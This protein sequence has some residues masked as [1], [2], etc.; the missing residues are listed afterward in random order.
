MAT[1]ATTPCETLDLLATT[2]SGQDRRHLGVVP[3]QCGRQV[4]QAQ[5]RQRLGH[6]GGHLSTSA[7]SLSHGALGL[8]RCVLFPCCSWPF[9]SAARPPPLACGPSQ[10]H[11]GN[12]EVICDTAPEDDTDARPTKISGAYRACSAAPSRFGFPVTDARRLH[13][14]VHPPLRSPVPCWPVALDNGAW[15]RE[16]RTNSRI[17]QGRRRVPDSTHSLRTLT[18]TGAARPGA[19]LPDLSRS[20]AWNRRACKSESARRRPQRAAAHDPGSTEM[21]GK[22]AT[23]RGGEASIG[24]RRWHAHESAPP[25]APR[26]RRSRGAGRNVQAIIAAELYLCRSRTAGYPERTGPV[27]LADLLTRPSTW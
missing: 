14:A 22:K 11:P 17:N 2:R 26:L 13:D 10:R 19:E 5:L 9:S 3:R 1:S 21:D 4:L 23:A 25:P 7:S 20:C 27:Q 24:D 15:S 6:R 18:G 16:R 8:S 12:H